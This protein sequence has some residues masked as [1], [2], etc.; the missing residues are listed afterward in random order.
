MLCPMKFF[1]IANNEFC[2]A[3]RPEG[4]ED[5]MECNRGR[6]A[7]WCKSSTEGYGECAIKSI[8]SIFDGLDSIATEIIKK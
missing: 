5:F 3:I 1:A 8:N 4:I 2:D 7:W 6:C